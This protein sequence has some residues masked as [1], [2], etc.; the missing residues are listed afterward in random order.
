LRA[1]GGRCD[2]GAYEVTPAPV[3]VTPHANNTPAPQ[4][5][6]HLSR[7]QVHSGK[8]VLLVATLSST[9][10]GCVSGTTVHAGQHNAVRSDRTG[11]ATIAVR[12]RHTGVETISASKPGCVTG[13][14]T[15]RVVHAH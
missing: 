8:R 15:L 3:T 5:T 13:T 2:I 9:D 11:H 1:A 10:H 4:I 12:F 14:A 6:L 7:N